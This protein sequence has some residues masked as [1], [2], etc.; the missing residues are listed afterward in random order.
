MMDVTPD[1][2]IR[3][4]VTFLGL[5][6]LDR[7]RLEHVYHPTTYAL[8][9]QRAQTTHFVCRALCELLAPAEVVVLATEKAE[10]AHGSALKTALRAGNF[11]SPKFVRIPVGESREQLW[12]QF[13]LIKEQLRYS[14]GPVMLDITHGFR[15]SPF[16]AAG[17][18]SFV[19][20]IDEDPPDLRVCYAGALGAGTDGTT[21]I[22]DLSEFVAL[23]DW[24]SALTLFLRTGRAEAAAAEAERIGRQVRQAWFTAGRIGTE[25]RLKELGES[26]RQFGKDLETLRTGDLLIGRGGKPSSAARLHAAVAAAREDVAI[27][28]PPLA[29]VLDRVAEMVRPLAGQ[30]MD[31]SGVEGHDAV[32]ALAETYLRFGRYLEAA[33]TIREG[34]VNQYASKAALAPGAPLFDGEERE[35]AEMAAYNSDP[36]FREV[37]DRRNDLLHGQYRR[38]GQSA[39]GIAGKVRELA[40]KFKASPSNQASTCFVNLTNHPSSHWEQDQTEAAL[41]LAGSVQDVRFPNVPPEASEKD[42]TTM[43]EACLAQLPRRATHALVQGEFTLAF[44]VV[45]QL[46]ERGITCLAATTQRVVEETD[47]GRKT[48]TF[49]FVR[50]RAY[51]LV[52][53]RLKTET[54]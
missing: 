7:N 32:M 52:G 14:T 46:Q 33:A 13:E 1:T 5:G 45:R 39:D 28:T 25:P 40:N 43:A 11:P 21:P 36:V 26:L 3:R 27:H 16:F 19:R 2:K 12:E 23:L 49:R 51:P 50:F 15:S 6:R 44:E 53:C 54:A 35:R 38:S 22:W 8:G 4:L 18:A 30:R 9:E 41:A 34:W 24:T 20:A 29:D 31:L 47:G 37:T 17:I 48:S 10:D 42:L